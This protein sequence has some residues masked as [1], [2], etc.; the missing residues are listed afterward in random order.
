MIEAD[1]EKAM[2]RQ[3]AM[4]R[5]PFVAVGPAAAVNPDDDR[6][7]LRRNGLGT[8]DV[9]E[10]RVSTVAGVDHIREGVNRSRDRRCG[11]NIHDDQV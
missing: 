7:R 9:Q 5:I 3:E 4:R 10:Q 2:F 8:Q 6:H 1:A 11:L